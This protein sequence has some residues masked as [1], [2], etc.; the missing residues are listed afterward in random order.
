MHAAYAKGN[1]PASIKLAKYQFSLL[2]CFNLLF[3]AYPWSY[4]NITLK[5]PQSRH[6]ILQRNY[7]ERYLNK[8][9]GPHP[10]IVRRVN[11][12]AIIQRA[13]VVLHIQG[14]FGLLSIKQQ[15]PVPQKGCLFWGGRSLVLSQKS[16]EREWVYKTNNSFSPL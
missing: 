11:Y 12:M 15:S 8:H 7:R 9:P 4:L 2:I 5:I 1:C 3:M 14:R 13:P 6:I 16:P 10:I